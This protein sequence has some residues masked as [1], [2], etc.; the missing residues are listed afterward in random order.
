MYLYDTSK[1]GSCFPIH[2]IRLCLFPESETIDVEILLLIPVLFLFVLLLLLLL[3]VVVVVIFGGGG[4]CVCLRM[5]YPSL[6]F[7]GLGL[8]IPCV[9]VGVISLFHWSFPSSTYS[10]AGSIDRNCLCLSLSRNVLPFPSMV[11]KVLLC[12]VD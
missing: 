6:N 3:L 1:S 2:S 4:G 12:I 7:A 10:G 9:F 5:C 11:L 8:F